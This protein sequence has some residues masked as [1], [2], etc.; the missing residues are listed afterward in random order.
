MS[1]LGITVHWHWDGEIRH[2]ILDFVR[3]AY[4]ISDIIQPSDHCTRLTSA[5]TGAYLAEKLVECL[6][7]YG[8]EEKVR[9]ICTCI[10][11]RLTPF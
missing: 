5:H 10:A 9:V 6:K 8:I 2:I 7:E 4:T 3:C 1:F 11:L